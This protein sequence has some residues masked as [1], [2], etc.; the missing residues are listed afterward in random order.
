[1]YVSDS[2]T[3][4]SEAPNIMPQHVQRIQRKES[5]IGRF[6]RLLLPA[7]ALASTG[8]A[9]TF[10]TFGPQVFTQNVGRPV[11]QAFTILDPTTTYTLQIDNNGVS[12]STVQLNGVVILGPKDFGKN[13]TVITKP[14]TLSAGSNQLTVEFDSSQT[15]S[16]TLRIIGVDNSP[17]TITAAAVPPP[18]AAGWNNSNVTVTFTCSDKTSGVASCSAPVTVASEGPNRVVTGTAVDKAGN[19]ATTSVTV[20]LDKSPPAITAT[21]T[22]A[23]NAAGWNNSNVT[24]QFNC[25]DTLSGIDTCSTPATVATEGSAQ[26]ISGTARDKAGNTAMA[27]TTIKLDKIPPTLTISSP[28]NGSVVTASSVTLTGIVAD[29]L[30]GVASVTCKGVPAQISAGNL[31]CTLTLAAGGNSIAVVA[32]DVAGNAATTNITLTISP[33]PTITITS[34]VSLTFLSTSP[35]TVNG[36]I[37]DVTATVNVNGIP[38]PQSNGKFSVLVPLIEGNNTI[39][40]VAQNAAGQAGTA[41]LQVTLDTT[42]PHVTITSP[43]NNFITTDG[44]ITVSGIV[45]DIVVGTVNDQQAQVTVNGMPAQV[46]NRSFTAAN[47]PLSVG[48]NTVQATARDRSGNAATTSAIVVRQ[49]LTGQTVLSVSS[50]NNQSGPIGVALP[51]PLTVSL[52][53]GAGQA[54]VNTPV[55]FKVTTGDGT[56]N[57]LSSV[58]VN[59]NAQGLAEVTMILGKHAGAGNNTVEA[60]TAGVASTAAFSETGTP[61]AAAL[62]IVDAGNNQTGAVGQ[63]LPLPFVAVVTDAGYNRLG[64]VPVTFTVRQGPAIWTA[65]LRRP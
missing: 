35:I 3:R 49:A 37:N 33:P 38:T 47:V 32:T 34:P 23:A 21:P 29:T 8:L 15:A 10:V 42:P 41:S 27:S 61:T 45:N 40:V 31:T 50:G 18:N 39:T 58:A 7:T 56:V 5:G 52:R 1:M 48:S 14:V 11:P 19:T 57:G 54:I 43:L 65:S 60:S 55:V 12:S 22:P 26:A 6:L 13:I 44:S 53:N 46:L 25:S 2:D 4:L 28:A 20:N 62:I 30:S 64:N 16:L 59:T 36:T 9:G 51:S 63:P 17:P 24:V